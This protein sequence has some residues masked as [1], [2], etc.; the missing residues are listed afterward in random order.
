[1]PAINISLLIDR[2]LYASGPVAIRDSALNIV[3]TRKAGE[4]VGVVDSWINRNGTL[5]L[6]LKPYQTVRLVKVPDPNLS[7]SKT[8]SREVFGRQEIEDAKRLQDIEEQKREAMGPVA[9]YI[10]RYGPILAAF[11]AGTYL[12]GAYIKKKA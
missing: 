4:V 5:Y 8:E 11:I 10:K 7:L 3:A 2:T 1:M 12:L 9:Y 6:T